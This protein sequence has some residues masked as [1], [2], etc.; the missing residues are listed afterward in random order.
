MIAELVSTLSLSII[1][2][3]T[4]VLTSQNTDFKN[5]LNYTI[6]NMIDQINTTNKT[7]YEE[8]LNKQ[9]YIDGL[10]KHLDVVKNDSVQKA[11]LAKNIKTQNISTNDISS[12]NINVA[13]KLTLDANK[14]DYYLQKNANRIQANSGLA[15]G[16][17][18]DITSGDG[19]S[20][21]GVDTDTGLVKIPGNM[22]LGNMKG[23]NVT[24]ENVIA[25]NVFSGGKLNMNNKFDMSTS[26]NMLLLQNNKGD[27]IANYTNDGIL[28]VTKSINTGDINVKGVANIDGNTNVSGNLNVNNISLSNGIKLT[29]EGPMIEKTNSNVGDRYGIGQFPGGSARM[30][31]SGGYVPSSV[32]LSFAKSDGNF[33][34][35]IQLKQDNGNYYRFG[36]DGAKMTTAKAAKQGWWSDIARP[37]D[38]VTRTENVG[39]RILIQNG[40]SAGI[41]VDKNSVGIGVE[42][43]YGALDVNGNI[44]SRGTD[45]SLGI[46]NTTYGDT[47]ASKALSKDANSQLVLNRG[48]DFKGVRVDGDLLHK[49][50]W[51]QDGDVFLRSK[52]DN[53]H[54]IGYYGEQKQF[55]NTNPDGPVVYGCQGGI[56]GTSC[57]GQKI[58]ANWDN[59]G[60]Y[61]S[62]IKHSR[63]WTGYPDGRNDG[64]EIANDTS[65]FKQLMIVGNKSGGGERR[66][67]IWDTLDVNGRLNVNGTLSVPSGIEVRNND[68]GPM[69]EKRYGNNAGDRYGIGQFPGGFTR[70]YSASANGP[71]SVN[72]GFAN[73]DNS[74]SDRLR[75]TND[76]KTTINGQLCIGNTCLT[77]AQLS[78]LKKQVGV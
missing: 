66:V 43:S 9:A 39:N 6:T 72:L 25:A 1:V 7:E 69:I 59:S 5:N 46:G 76:G 56:L 24:A 63:N 4:V 67:G 49:N 64:A 32:N 54:G 52:G 2:I 48:N 41:V 71:A 21:F 3:V 77:E 17:G 20:K 74:F 34:D 62:G 68:P 13:S 11:E 70:V 42:P 12:S 38:F 78:S 75:I 15:T 40:K 60:F 50:T 30:Y 31:S 19:V 35:V 29:N 23:A 27:P 58:A 47:G 8:S 44:A 37:D 65:G 61:T 16:S 10:E 73:S 51:T 33:N 36:G 22:A 14:G 57:G 55:S 53:N 18:F 28:S 26:N 45:F